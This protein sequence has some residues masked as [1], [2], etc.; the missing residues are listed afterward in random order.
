MSCS[1]CVG[2]I[3]EVFEVKLWISLV[4]VGFLI[5]MV[6]VG[7]YGKE[8]VGEFVRVIVLVGYEVILGELI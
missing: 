2:K 1:F 6:I 4:S 7:F 5:Y 3:I 8:Y